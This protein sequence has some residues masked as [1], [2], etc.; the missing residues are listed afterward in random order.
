MPAVKFALFS[1]SIHAVSNSVALG[2][3]SSCVGVEMGGVVNWIAPNYMGV[4]KMQWSA[5]ALALAAPT[6]QCVGETHRPP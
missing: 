3:D 5:P 1:H 6:V 2:Q 4:Q